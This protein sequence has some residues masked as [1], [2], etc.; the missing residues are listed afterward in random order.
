MSVFDVI[1]P[2]KEGKAAVVGPHDLMLLFDSSQT[3][4]VPYHPDCLLMTE[5]IFYEAVRSICEAL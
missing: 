1:L 5:A 4:T 2:G 3:K